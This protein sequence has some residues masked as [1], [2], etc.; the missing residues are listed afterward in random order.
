MR[1][2]QRKL[3]IGFLY[4]L[5]IIGIILL[6]FAIVKRSFKDWIIVYLVS[7]LGNSMADRYLVSRGFLKYDIRPFKKSLKIHFPF[8]YVHYPLMLL[9]YNQWTLNSKPLGIILKLF[10]FLIPQVLVETFAAKKTNLITWKRGWSWQHSFFS[11]AIKMLLC[12][13]IISIIR[14]INR[15]DLSVD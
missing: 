1:K 8:D 12:R 14:I 9:Y 15:D 13:G 2:N 10:P 3:S 7:I 11:L 4:S 5:T 6:P